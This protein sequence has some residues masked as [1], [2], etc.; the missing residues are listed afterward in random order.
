MNDNFICWLKCLLFKRNK[1]PKVIRK[2]LQEFQE[3]LYFVSSSS[4]QKNFSEI[5]QTSCWE[6]NKLSGLSFGISG[7]LHIFVFLGLIDFSTIRRGCHEVK[8][9][10]GVKNDRKMS[11]HLRHL[12]AEKS[13]CKYQCQFTI[14]PLNAL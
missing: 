10:L 3:I 13:R 12:A 7:C 4:F 14:N 6:V 2:F 5:E 11:I 9:K 1:F 8:I